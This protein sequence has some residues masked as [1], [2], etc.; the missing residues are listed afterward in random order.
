MA[1]PTCD[2]YHGGLMPPRAT[3]DFRRRVRAGGIPER[4]RYLCDQHARGL[5][6]WRDKYR[7]PSAPPPEPVR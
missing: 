5:A 1:Q 6:G 7:L 2:A 3:V 4:V